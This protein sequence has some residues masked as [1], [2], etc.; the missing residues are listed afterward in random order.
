MSNLTF[1]SNGATQVALNKLNLPNET[2]IQVRKNSGSWQNY[3]FGSSIALANDDT[4][5]FSGNAKFSKDMQN[6]YQFSTT[7]EGTLAVSG[8]LISLVSSSVIEDDC[9][10]NSLFKD[11]TNIVDA[12]DLVLPSNVTNWCYSNMFSNCSGLINSPT[13]L[14]AIELADWCYQGMFAGCTSLTSG[15]KLPARKIANYSYY[16]MFYLCKSLQIAPYLPVKR[17]KNWI[18][19][20]MFYRC[21]NLDQISSNLLS[22]NQN[23]T[24]SWTKRVSRQGS[25]IKREALSTEHG[26]SR[27]PNGWNVTVNQP[28]FA[29]MPLTFRSVGDTTVQLSALGNQTLQNFF[30]KINDGDWQD[31]NEL[32]DKEISLT[33]ED[34]LSFKSTATR[35]YSG[36]NKYRFITTGS[37]YLELFGNIKSINND[38][39]T[40]SNY[41]YDML[42]NGCA[43]IFDAQDLILPASSLAERCYY[44]MFKNCY[45]L[46]YIPTIPATTLADSCCPGMFEGCSSIIEVPS[47]LLSATTLAYDCYDAMFSGCTSLTAAPELPAATLCSNCYQYMFAKCKNL[48]KGPSTIAATATAGS[49]CK[50]MFFECSSLIVAPQLPAT[51]LGTECYEEMFGKCTSLTSAPILPALSVEFESYRYM[52]RECT[53]LSTAPTL[54]ATTLDNY[55]YQ[56]MFNKCTSLTDPPTLPAETLEEGCYNLMFEGCSSLTA[57]PELPATSLANECYKSMFLDCTGLTSCPQLPATT[58]ANSCYRDMFYGCTYIENAPTNL[59]AYTLA[60]SC[61]YGMFY[62]C[63]KLKKAPLIYGTTLTSRCMQYMFYNCKSLSAIGV[64]F[65]DWNSSVNATQNWVMGVPSGG[66]FQKYTALPTY[67]GTSNIPDNWNVI[68]V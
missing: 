52:F 31:Y 33:L 60:P 54:P 50:N 7:G 23:G 43:N 10:F 51:T 26:I 2:T 34:Q 62:N 14:P 59:S 12:T 29:N 46:T 19:N 49:S 58:L 36:S 16:A 61:Y 35:T 37:G 20:S 41:N 3:S 11:C 27:I 17:L 8:D 38:L 5:E 9:E 67:F 30:Y 4:V 24:K 64:L 63:Y 25:F 13:L 1:K 68:N 57:C 21:D 40:V 53:S 39:S 28:D 6:H 48:I 65:T 32:E 66:V 56:G 55:C 47:G 18:Y 15:P 22:W 44:A 42:F 45:D